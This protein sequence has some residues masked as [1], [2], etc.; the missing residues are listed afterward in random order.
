MYPFMVFVANI[1]LN[2]EDVMLTCDK[3]EVEKNKE[4]IC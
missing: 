3:W 1:D 2:V 4:V